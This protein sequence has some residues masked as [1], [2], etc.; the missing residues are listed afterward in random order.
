MW[1]EIYFA[2]IAG[3]VTLTYMIDKIYWIAVDVNEE[4]EEES[5]VPEFVKHMFS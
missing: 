5:E 3:L 1:I 4:E 2:I